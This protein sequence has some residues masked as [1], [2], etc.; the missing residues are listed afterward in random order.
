MIWI[1]LVL[2]GAKGR[3]SGGSAS[4]LGRTPKARAS[5]QFLECDRGAVAFVPTV[6]TCLNERDQRLTY[7]GCK[8]ADGLLFFTL[9][10]SHPEG[11]GRDISIE[12][13]SF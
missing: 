10:K 3:E 2:G 5:R 9:F 12:T 8:P 7:L 4:L 13:E 11:S 6:T 1:L